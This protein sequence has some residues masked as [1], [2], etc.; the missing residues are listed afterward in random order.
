MSLKN[1]DKNHKNLL[2]DGKLILMTSDGREGL[3]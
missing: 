3:E 1:A 2:N